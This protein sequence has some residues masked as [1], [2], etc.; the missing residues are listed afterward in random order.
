MIF[1]NN[2]P[3]IRIV[4]RLRLKQFGIGTGPAFWHWKKPILASRYR[5]GSGINRH[6]V[7]TGES[8]GGK[9]NAARVLLTELHSSGSNILIIDPHGDYLGIAD[10][11]GADVYDASRS[12]INLF[13][14]DGMA[15]GEKIAELMA[16][17]ARR[18]RLG[19]VQAS[20]L[21]RCVR[22]CYWVMK[23]RG[24]VPTV[25]SLLYTIRRFEARSSGS[26][27]RTLYTLHERVSL[28]DQSSFFSPVDAKKAMA[29]NSLFLLSTLHTDEAQAV[30]MEALLRKAYSMMLAGRC[31]NNYLVIDE[32]GKVS[33]SRVLGRLVAEGR[34]YG[35]GVITISQKIWEIESNVL[36]NSSTFISF[37]QREPQELNY[38]ANYLSG[39]RELGRFAEVKKEIRN[40]RVG[41]AIAL[42]SALREPV[43]LAFSLAAARQGSLEHLILSSAERGIS[44]PALERRAERN[45]FSADETAAKINALLK[46]GTLKAHEVKEGR[47]KGR[48][49]VSYSRNSAEHDLFVGLISRKLDM[50]GISNEILNSSYGPDI[51]AYTEGKAIA[52]EYETGS[53]ELHETLHMLES[54][55]ARYAEVVVITNESS[56][57]KYLGIEG[58]T[59]LRLSSVLG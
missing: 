29:R 18:L 55:R 50:H 49:L 24:A 5:I 15:E 22:Y 41:H 19:H 17:L 52:I 53:K 2:N 28:L 34:K 39:G 59:L 13:D 45:L 56:Y 16:V 23:K 43:V 48:W 30:Y 14:L 35:L 11:I 12:S 46:E 6:I 42:D 3:R 57:P 31:T 25:K 58:I 37:Y 9:S 20:T 1:K 8:G 27:L 4:K 38:A 47:M 44:H 21:R 33:G 7:I 10:A 26:E 32:A 51:V 36:S 54:R 40:L